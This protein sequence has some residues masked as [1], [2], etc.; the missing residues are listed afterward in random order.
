MWVLLNSDDDKLMSLISPGDRQ[1]A[2]LRV[3]SSSKRFN[4]VE[5]FQAEAAF[6]ANAVAKG[7]AAGTLNIRATGKPSGLLAKHHQPPPRPTVRAESLPADR[8][9]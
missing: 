6:V 4:G 1:L 7:A 5:D 2:Y 3:A 9:A 8:C